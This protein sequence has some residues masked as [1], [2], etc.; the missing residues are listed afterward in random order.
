MRAE[1]RIQN[2]EKVYVIGHPLGLPQMYTGPKE[3]YEN[4]P[5]VF[6]MSTLDTY[7]YHSGSPVINAETHVVEGVLTGGGKEVR[8]YCGCDAPAASTTEHG[9]STSMAN[10]AQLVVDAIA[11]PEHVVVVN[12]TATSVFVETDEEYP[13]SGATT[14][15]I[16]H[17]PEM[18]LFQLPQFGDRDATVPPY[19]CMIRYQPQPGETWKI[20]ESEAAGGVYMIRCTDELPA[21]TF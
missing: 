14:D 20:V 18:L 21:G 8:S 12:E 7:D 15:T 3:L 13:I 9:L 6:F 11:L 4:T 5:C 2:Y 19:N 16:P 1:G 10:R 17:R